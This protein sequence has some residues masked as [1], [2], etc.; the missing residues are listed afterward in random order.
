MIKVKIST[1][2]IV[3]TFTEGKDFGLYRYKIIRGLPP[4]CKL[5]LSYHDSFGVMTLIFEDPKNSSDRE[6]AISINRELIDQGGEQ[7]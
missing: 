1:D 4:G 6:I 7:I 2:L 3:D 5:I